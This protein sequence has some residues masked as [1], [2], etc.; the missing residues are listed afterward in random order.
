MS[1]QATPPSLSHVLNYYEKKFLDL[2]VTFTPYKCFESP[3]FQHIITKNKKHLLKAYPLFLKTFK[4]NECHD[5]IV[6]FL[7]SH[8][9]RHAI[10]HKRAFEFYEF[11]INNKLLTEGQKDTLQYEFSV[12]T[13]L[14]SNETPKNFKMAS[15]KSV[16]NCKI[17]FQKPSLCL[18][19]PTK[20]LYLFLY[21]DNQT[22]LV[23][24]VECTQKEFAFIKSMETDK[25]IAEI[26]KSRFDFMTKSD[27]PENEFL[28]ILQSLITKKVI[29]ALY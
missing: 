24:T 18:N 15:D 11:I 29:A 23:K 9:I 19:L 4:K 27:N 26:S 12:F 10:P 17:A 8:D 28:G 13:L 25:L 7:K 16:L 6:D 21:R 20:S 22:H 2:P 14:F 5:L 3:S 1:T